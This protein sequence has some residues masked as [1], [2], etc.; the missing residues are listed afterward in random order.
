MNLRF[1]N[2]LSE[3]LHAQR[4]GHEG[5]AASCLN[6]A[7]GLIAPQAVP[8]VGKPEDDPNRTEADRAAWRAAKGA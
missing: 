8:F 4:A 5:K 3:A 1:E 7:L 6:E 2:L